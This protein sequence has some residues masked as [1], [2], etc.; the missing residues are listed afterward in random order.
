MPLPHASRVGEPSMRLM[1]RRFRIHEAT[2]VESTQSGIPNSKTAIVFQSHRYLAAPDGT[3]YFKSTDGHN[4]NWSFSTTRL[5]LHV[6]D[7]A[8]AHNGAL[9]IDAT[10]K[11]KMAPV[12]DASSRAI[13]LHCKTAHSIST[14]SRTCTTLRNNYCAPLFIRSSFSTVHYYGGGGLGAVNDKVAIA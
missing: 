11:G 13:C 10:R 6:V 9:I 3:C 14:C 12:S 8:A 1:V 4:N 7:I 5:N 2:V